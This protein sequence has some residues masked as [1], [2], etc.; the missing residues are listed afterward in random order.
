MK[1]ALLCLILLMSGLCM[2]A[3]DGGVLRIVGN[4][5][6]A[7]GALVI[8]QLEN[9]RV[10]KAD[11]VKL[12]DGWVDVN[13]K[14]D[15]PRMLYISRA[16]QRGTQQRE[17]QPRGRRP[18]TIQ[19]VGVPGE[20][21]QI[22]G[23]LADYTIL[24]SRFYQ[25][26]VE[27]ADALKPLSEESAALRRQTDQMIANGGDRDEAMNKY[28]EGAARIRQRTEQAIIDFAKAHPDNE[29]TVTYLEQVN[30]RN[31]ERFLGALT[32]AVRDGRMKPYYQ[33]T[34]DMVKAQMERQERA[35]KLQEAGREVPDFTLMDINGK[36]LSLSSL[37]GKY[38]VLDFWGS[39]CG[40]CI[41]GF[42]EMK[43]YYEKY[44][45]KFEILGIDCNDTEEKWKKAVEDNQLPWLHVYNKKDDNDVTKIFGITGYPTKIIID[46]QGRIARSI[47]GESP[48][49]YVYLDEL[50]K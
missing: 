9:R 33:P 8:T 15:S 27:M 42:P 36:P 28:Q 43:K 6:D 19:I 40:W 25:Q 11:T 13:L 20:T 39:W 17:A 44:K 50:F 4:I 2:K 14:M 26:Y 12:N 34:V 16:Q 10:V 47:I 35:A 22:V 38:V 49:F 31:W 18:A 30:P 5:R 32:P 45:D 21:L 23:T 37:R 3:A 41:K 7:A 24:G 46:P 29:A 1:K 48:E